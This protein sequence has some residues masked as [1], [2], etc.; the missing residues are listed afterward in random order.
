[1]SV[2][3]GITRRGDLW[4]V[5]LREP[6][7]VTGKT[8]M[9][10]HSGFR[11]ED[12]AKAFRDDRRVSLR[13]GQAVRKDKITVAQYLEEWLPM[14]AK[15]KQLSPNTVYGYDRQISSYVIPYIGKL[16][17]QE[18]TPVTISRLY[19]DLSENFAPRTV[20][21]TGT[22]L[23]IAFKHAMLVYRIIEVDPTRDVPIPRPKKKVKETW[24]VEQMRLVSVFMAKHPNGALYQVMA[25]TGCRRSEVLGLRWIDVDLSEGVIKFTQARVLA[26]GQVIIKETLKN[27]VGKNVPIDDATVDALRIYRTKQKEAKMK[28]LTWLETGLVFT[29]SHGNGVYPSNIYD[30]WRKICEQA[31]VPYL[32]PHGLRHTHATW[33]LEAGVPLH[34]VAER[35]GHRDAMVTAT[36]YAQV[37]GNQA[38]GASDI[39]AEKMGN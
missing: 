30:D 29:N 15:T 8:K 34:V 1:M 14:H 28:S 16:K 5:V 3:D 6:D 31:G 25:A 27:G 22:V 17:M 32:K 36:I 26:G 38:R 7:P 23:R 35:L 19:S 37:T 13:K 10:W 12:E 21:Y 11:S 18:V 4:Y 20:E 2:K 33:L 24:S 39:F 9:V